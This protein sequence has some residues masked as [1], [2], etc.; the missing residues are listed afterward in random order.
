MLWSSLHAH[1]SQD[2]GVGG[3]YER[4]YPLGT[5]P[6]KSTPAY[7]PVAQSVSRLPGTGGRP[8][9][10]R[11]VSFG[12]PALMR[13]KEK[14]RCSPTDFYSVGAERGRP[15]TEVRRAWSCMR[16]EGRDC[17]HQSCAAV[18]S[19]FFGIG[20]LRCYSSRA[21]GSIGSLPLLFGL[22]SC[23]PLVGFL[24]VRPAGRCCRCSLWSSRPCWC[25]FPGSLAGSVAARGGLRCWSLPSPRLSFL[26]FCLRGSRLWYFCR[27]RR[28]Y[29]FWPF[30]RHFPSCGVPA[31]WRG[32]RNV[33]LGI[34]RQ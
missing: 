2:K 27:F 9:H 33:V 21:L 3:N 4:W 22:W 17:V 14:R 25:F 29:V 15:W 32:L 31:G 28:G 8:T 13:H 1:K 12:A 7:T 24:R 18:P 30:L 34:C 10:C 23:S 6:T 20:G 11:R 5:T 16:R 26:V 19:A